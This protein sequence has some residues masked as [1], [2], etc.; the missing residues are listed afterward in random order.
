[1]SQE[2]DP[3]KNPPV[4]VI[5]EETLKNRQEP[6][7]CCDEVSTNRWVFPLTRKK[8]AELLIRLKYDGLKRKELGV[9]LLE[10]YLNNDEDFIRCLEKIQD[11]FQKKTRRG[12]RGRYHASYSLRKEKKNLNLFEGAPGTH[13]ISPEDMPQDLLSFEEERVTAEE[14][15]RIKRM[16][17]YYERKKKEKEI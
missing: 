9:G 7:S 6:Y 17:E 8:Y 10:L 3:T 13:T 16:K 15:K 1:M 14:Q 12:I 4:I 2:E 11:R 5:S